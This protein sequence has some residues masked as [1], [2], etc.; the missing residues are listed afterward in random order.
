MAFFFG[1]WVSL[2]LTSSCS[3]KINRL[4]SIQP[5]AIDSVAE[6][7]IYPSTTDTP[8][9]RWTISAPSDSQNYDQT[10][11]ALGSTVGG[12]DIQEWTK[13]TGTS[14]SRSGLALTP[15]K[16]YYST[17][18][19]LDSAGSVLTTSHGTSW[20]AVL[21]VSVSARYSVAPNWNDYAQSATPTN[22]CL[23]TEAGYFACLHGGEK[24]FVPFSAASDCSGYTASDE[25]GAFDWACDATG[26]A[27]NV[28]FYSTALK[29]SKALADLLNAS[30]WRENRVLISQNGIPVASSPR[31]VWWSNPVTPLPDSPTI[32]SPIT[33]SGSGTIFTVSSTRT[34]T[35][36]FQFAA[37]AS[38]YKIGIAVFPGAILHLSDQA[39]QTVCGASNNQSCVFNIR[40]SR[41]FWFEGEYRNDWT[42]YF[43]GY[44]VLGFNAAHGVIRRAKA[45]GFFG[46]FGSD[47][48]PITSSFFSQLNA[49]RN[50]FGVMVYGS[51]NIIDRL[52]STSVAG[53]SIYLT[54]SFAGDTII[55]SSLLQSL[56]VANNANAIITATQVIAAINILGNDATLHNVRGS[57]GAIIQGNSRT[58]FS[59]FAVPYFVLANSSNNKFTGNWLTD[60][61]PSCT[62]VAGTNPGI[63]SSCAIQG[64]LSNFTRTTGN[65]NHLVLGPITI[66]DTANASDSN[67]AQA[68]ASIVDWVN[69]ENPWRMW[70]TSTGTTCT[71]GTCQIFDFRLS[72]SDTRYRNTTGNGVAQNAAFVSGGACP[73]WLDGNAY[74]RDAA[75]TPRTYLANAIELLGTGGNSNGLCESGENCLY[76]PNFGLYQGEGDYTLKSCAIGTGGTI[77]NVRL[78]SY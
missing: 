40:D 63:D 61:G 4:D 42:A 20:I 23:G 35:E 57:G 12:T 65:G 7:L 74:L 36:G 46:G 72:P 75:S 33:L 77:Q 73:A 49:S 45:T 50:Q 52:V 70:A 58:T 29:G 67:G 28:F 59:Q 38:G 76:T 60:V 11:I 44:N 54:P 24:K 68:F 10:Q 19:L 78:Y 3:V 27:G 37:G 22:A 62:V 51:N 13:V 15:G 2:A 66:D 30:S 6:N 64:A 25:L 43:S 48:S 31:M 14:W 32:G 34:V 21:P 16:S 55:Q 18:R 5:L 56:N 17:V 53:D 8:I 26:G 47:S 71:S 39:S 41:F 69:F 1:A 9:I